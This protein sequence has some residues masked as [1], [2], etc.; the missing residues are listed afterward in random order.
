MYP[1]DKLVIHILFI[2]ENIALLSLSS[3]KR[4]IQ[5]SLRIVDLLP[6]AFGK[7]FLNYFFHSFYLTTFE[8]EMKASMDLVLPKCQGI[9]RASLYTL[10]ASFVIFIPPFLKSL[11]W[12]FP[13][14]VVYKKHRKRLCLRLFR[15]TWVMQAGTNS[16]QSKVQKKKVNCLKSQQ[17]LKFFVQKKYI[18]I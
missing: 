1:I 17:I 12:L 14:I 15:Q 9:V 11:L 16:C 8:L 7:V 6:Q 4:F 13:R 10:L 2:A 5:C 18:Y 3:F